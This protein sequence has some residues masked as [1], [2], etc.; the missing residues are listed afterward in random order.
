MCSCTGQRNEDGEER[1]WGK[2][3]GGA[4]DGKS[5][6]CQQIVA[7]ERLPGDEEGAVYPS[8]LNGTG[9]GHRQDTAKN[10]KVSAWKDH[11]PAVARQH[12]IRHTNVV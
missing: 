8:A 12:R 11:L 6:T 4:R 1:R 3:G 2:R 10:D 7:I 5:G 9:L